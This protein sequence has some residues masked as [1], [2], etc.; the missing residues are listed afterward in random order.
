MEPHKKYMTTDPCEPMLTVYFKVRQG[1]E[2]YMKYHILY[3]FGTFTLF[4]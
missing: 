4:K 3:D 2:F 1:L